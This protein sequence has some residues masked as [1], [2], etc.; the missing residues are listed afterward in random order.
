MKNI[1]L[2]ELIEIFSADCISS[3]ETSWKA[4]A[5]SLIWIFIYTGRRRRET[6]W[7]EYERKTYFSM[8]K[9]RVVIQANRSVSLVLFLHSSWSSHRIASVSENLWLYIKMLP[10]YA[11]CKK[12]I[13]AY[14]ACS[15]SCFAI[16]YNFPL[17]NVCTFFLH[18]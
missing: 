17:L 2:K 14:E 4:Q 1:F 7:S 10:H 9:H 3:L 18:I 15:K 11:T 13:I 5:K 8:A 6:W 12:L 16:L